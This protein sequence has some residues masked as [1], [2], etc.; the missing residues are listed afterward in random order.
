MFFSKYRGMGLKKVESGFRFLPNAVV[1]KF[2]LECLS[3]Y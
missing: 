2:T 3:V 1:G